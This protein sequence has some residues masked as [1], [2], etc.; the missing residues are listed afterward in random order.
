MKKKL[1]FFCLVLCFLSCKKKLIEPVESIAPEIDFF[2]SNYFA[3]SEVNNFKG[4]VKCSEPAYW[5]GK[6]LKL[7]G[8]LFSGN[9]NTR[10][11][12]FF[13][14]DN[15][16]VFEAT[17]RAFE[18]YYQSKDSIT[19]SRILLDSVNK[20]KHCLM[21]VTCFTTQTVIE[22]CVKVV[23]FTLTKPEDLEFK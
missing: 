9:I 23:K 11:K 17:N 14:Y 10:D 3:P 21:Q 19:I 1:I 2:S 5:E 7:Q 15:I 8:F 6:R 4:L 16:K 20:D 18:V 13:V 12:K 22:G